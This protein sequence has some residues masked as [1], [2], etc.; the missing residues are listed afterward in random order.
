[1]AYFRQATAGTA[2][3]APRRAERIA[4]RMEASLRQPSFSKFDVLVSDLSTDGFKCETHYRVSPNATVWLTIP[5]LAPLESRVVWA[6]GN[7][8]GCSFTQP[9][10][11][12]V[13]EHVARLHP[14]SG[15]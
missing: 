10:H 11:V 2:I 1:M 13:M 7:A 4:V 8:Y 14:D 12:A 9:L 15:H 3:E 5:G 6:N